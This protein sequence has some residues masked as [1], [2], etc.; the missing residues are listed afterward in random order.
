MN[1]AGVSGAGRDSADIAVDQRAI[2][3]GLGVRGG[4]NVICTCWAVAFAA[5]AEP[6]IIG[7]LPQASNHPT[8]I[9]SYFTQMQ[10]SAFQAQDYSD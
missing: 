6:D 7:F 1:G 10:I 9:F 2:S 5:A 4:V 8:A 3:A